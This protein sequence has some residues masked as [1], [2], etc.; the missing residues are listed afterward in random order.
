VVHGGVFISYRGEDSHS[1]GA[2]LHAELSRRFGSELVF[3]DS[4]SIPPGEDFVDQLLRKVRQA[5]VVLAVIG[6]QWLTA[7][8]PSGGR[9]IDDSGD[10]IRRES[11][12]ALPVQAGAARAGGVS[13]LATYRSIAHPPTSPG[14]SW[15]THGV[16]AGPRSPR[17]GPATTCTASSPRPRHL[18]RASSAAP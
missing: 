12:A 16:R 10:W 14:C 8:R 7:E 15:P 4:A 13:V 3:L 17:P 1:Y 5:R 11:R 9:R 2:L 18:P 6:A